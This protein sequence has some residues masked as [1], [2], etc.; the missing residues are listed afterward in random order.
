MTAFPC[1]AFALHHDSGV[2]VQD[3]A[4]RLL[5]VLEG[6]PASVS[7][8]VAVTGPTRPTAYRP[9]LALRKIRL[10]TR[11]ARGSYQLGPRLSEMAILEHGDRMRSQAG[12]LLPELRART[13][14]SARL[15]RSCEEGKLCVAAA[16]TLTAHPVPVGTVLTAWPGAAAQIPIAWEEPEALH[17][18]LVGARFTA[19]TL[20]QVRRRGWTQTLDSADS[21]TATLAAPVRGPGG[22]AVAALALTGPATLL[23]GGPAGGA[24]SAAS[25]AALRLGEASDA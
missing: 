6:G 2:G 9:A 19:E 22:R 18:G 11:D 17:K 8:I 5:S 20:A 13:G 12:S 25:G 3:K 1:P 21:S 24:V 14:V 15:Y 16:G 4:S 23:T 10:V 7:R